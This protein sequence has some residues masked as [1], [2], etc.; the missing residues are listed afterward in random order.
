M[1][2]EIIVSAMEEVGIACDQEQTDKLSE[3]LFKSYEELVTG[4]RT[5]KDEI[6][7]KYKRATA[8]IDEMEKAKNE[9]EEKFKPYEAIPS[10]QEALEAIEKLKNND[11]EVDI[12]AAVERR[13]KVLREEIDNL[14]TKSDAELRDAMLEKDSLANQM[15]KQ[16]FNFEVQKA[17][18]KLNVPEK[19]VKHLANSMAEVFHWDEDEKKFIAVDS[20]GDKIFDPVNPAKHVDFHT[21]G[22]MLEKEEPYLF[23]KDYINPSIGGNKGDSESEDKYFSIR[24]SNIRLTEEGLI[25]RNQNPKEFEQ[26]KKRFEN[27]MKRKT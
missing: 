2:K 11:T 17:A 25:L 15:I 22:K 18:S 9:L 1:Q 19:A 13:T 5:N 10:A 8:K 26:L 24:G 16:K 3:K 14:R 12:E 20:N 23:N 21:Y 27:K 6:L 7:D 4:L